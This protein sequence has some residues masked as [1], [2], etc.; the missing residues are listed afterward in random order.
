[1]LTLDHKLGQMNELPYATRDTYKVLG[2]RY[3]L[4]SIYILYSMS[5]K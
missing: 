1:M 5:N 4:Y 2:I 3:Y